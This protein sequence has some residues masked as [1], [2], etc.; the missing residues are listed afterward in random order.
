MTLSK[1][2]SDFSDAMALKLRLNREARQSEDSGEAKQ[3]KE[4]E[5]V[6]V[7]TNAPYDRSEEIRKLGGEAKETEP[8]SGLNILDLYKLYNRFETVY[9]ISDRF[10]DLPKNRPIRK[11]NPYLG[12]T[13]AKRANPI[14]LVMNLRVP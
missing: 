11:L 8:V 4:H 13:P 1:Y 7:Q 10:N 2:D 6:I 9:L 14:R 12:F 3:S 5:T